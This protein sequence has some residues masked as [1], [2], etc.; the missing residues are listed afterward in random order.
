MANQHDGTATRC[1]FCRDGAA[2]L[3][4]FGGN[5]H[6]EIFDGDLYDGTYDVHSG[7]KRKMKD[8]IRVFYCPMCGRDLQSGDA[9]Q[10][11]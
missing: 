10:D 8:G 6:A 2:P 1:R 3:Y 9:P 4:A 7:W 5:G 11:R